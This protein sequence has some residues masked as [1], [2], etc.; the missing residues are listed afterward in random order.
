MIPSNSRVHSSPAVVVAKEMTSPS[1]YL[2]N[3]HWFYRDTLVILFQSWRNSAI[4]LL[5]IAAWYEI[6]ELLEDNDYSRYW[7]LLCLPGLC[8]LY[9]GL[10]LTSAILFKWLLV[11]K[12][13]PRTY[14]PG[15]WFAF[16]LQL[17]DAA[18]TLPLKGGSLLPIFL[19]SLYGKGLGMDIP[20]S[21]PL[22]DHT[23]KASYDLVSVGEQT[24]LGGNVQFKTSVQKDGQVHL[25]KISIGAHCR[26]GATTCI[27]AGVVVPDGVSF[28]RAS[29]IPNGFKLLPN[30]QYGGVP[31]AR[32]GKGP[33]SPKSR[34]GC[35]YT[36]LD[37]FFWLALFLLPLCIVA[38]ALW[39]CQLSNLRGWR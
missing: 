29:Y 26:A 2:G 16:R 3:A 38:A 17:A 11:Q 10:F 28:A 31:I 1:T 27:D 19:T 24:S 20:F 15:S 33:P 35:L 5:T 6:V 13:K 36:L 37:F 8:L 25:A 18:V 7:V 12:V 32:L 4:L 9:I 21:S 22:F 14:R 39:Y 34:L 23:F 30:S